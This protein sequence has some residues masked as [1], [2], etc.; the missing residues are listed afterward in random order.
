VPDLGITQVRFGNNVRLVVKQTDFEPGRVRV[1]LNFGEGSSRLFDAP[2][3][4]DMAIQA[5]FVTGGLESYEIDELGRALAGRTVGLGFGVGAE[6]YGMSATT[7]RADLLVQLQLF[8]AYLT[9]P[10]FRPDGFNQLRAARDGMFRGLRATPSDAYGNFGGPL[11]LNNDQRFARIT[12]QEFDALRPEVARAR[13]EPQ[14]RDGPIEI[15]IVG[16]IPVGEAI[17]NVQRTLAQLPPRR[18]APEPDPRAL[19]ALFTPGRGEDVIEHEGRADQSLAMIFWPMGDYG[20]GSEARAV[21]LLTEVMQIRLNEVIREEEGGTYSPG[22]VWN[23]S[24]LYPGYGVIGATM[25]VKPEDAARLLARVEAVA[26]D[27]AAGNISEDLYTRARTPLIADFEE[28]RRNNPWW[29]NWLQ[30]SSWEP[31]NLEIIRGG[32]RHYEQVTLDRLKQLAQQY[33]DPSK[34]RIIRVVPGPNAQPIAE[35]AAPA[36]APASGGSR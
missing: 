7:T 24:T 12:E 14:L 33:L 3:G 18:L 1:A 29:L 34:A 30:G 15:V 32:Q 26:A 23:P 10:A 22:A 27:L 31:R 36:P 16:D 35:A 20:D 17:T 6:S 4:T 28:T 25:E 13:L 19:Q 2:K 21:R 9:Q 5:M 11:L 8:G